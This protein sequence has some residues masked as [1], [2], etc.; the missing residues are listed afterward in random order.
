MNDSS[1]RRL[2]F[3]RLSLTASFASIVFAASDVQAI[4]V[5]VPIDLNPGGQYR[6][7]FITGAARDGT[8]E[9]INDYNTFVT[10]VAD[11]VPQLAALETTWKA[12]CSTP[13]VAARDNTVTNPL[14]APGVPI[15]D[16]TGYGV[17]N[18][19]ADLWDGTIDNDGIRTTE[20]GDR[21][22]AVDPQVFTGTAP[23]GTP[24]DG[25][26]A[27]GEPLG[28]RPQPQLE[29]VGRPFG[30][31]NSVWITSTPEPSTT[32][33]SFLAISGVLTVPAPPLAGDYN[34]NGVID[35]ADYVVW[36]KNL[37]GSTSLPNDDTPGV[38]LDDYT[39]WRT[40]FGQAAGSGARVNT[41]AA[42]PEP[43]T[44]V[45]LMFAATGWFLRRCRPR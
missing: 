7:V 23:D 26:V 31:P 5:T 9:D 10:N 24:A 32:P 17:V 28:K 19:N 45:M 16:L 35:G 20:T 30:R 43:A 33:M 36:R 37:G 29:T 8:S 25:T 1:A 14:L 2:R 41:N 4:P 39:R 3:V 38:G 42:V 15:Y 18:S 6:L 44:L 11:S 21:P 40:D 27:M 13:T 12:I 22:L 34:Q